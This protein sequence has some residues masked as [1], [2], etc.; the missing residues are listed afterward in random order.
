[1]ETRTVVLDLDPDDYDAVQ[2]AL[3][4]RQT[5]RAMPEGGGNLAGRVAGDAGRPAGRGLTWLSV[6]TA[7]GG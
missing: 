1:V 4:V 7:T 3:A 6:P 5:F 2:R